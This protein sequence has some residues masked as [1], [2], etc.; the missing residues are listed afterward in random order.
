MPI[1]WPELGCQLNQK[2]PSCCSAFCGLLHR[3]LHANWLY[4]ILVTVLT[5]H[6][7]RKELDSGTFAK[8]IR[9]G[10]LPYFSFIDPQRK[11]YAGGKFGLKTVTQVERLDR[12][13]R[14]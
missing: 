13:F 9:K 14:Y 3:A 7:I 11:L 4:S 8:T 12:L 6:H 1:K 2:P 10:N 5:I